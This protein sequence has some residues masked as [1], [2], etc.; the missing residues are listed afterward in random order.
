MYNMLYLVGTDVTNEVMTYLKE[1]EFILT[2]FYFGNTK[3]TD[4][5]FKVLTEMNLTQLENI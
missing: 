4:E 2:F 1:E 3:I 5:G